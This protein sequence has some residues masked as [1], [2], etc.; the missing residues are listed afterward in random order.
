[1]KSGLTKSEGGQTQEAAT[2]SGVE[3]SMQ[4]G[5]A[6]Y[7]GVISDMGWGTTLLDRQADMGQASSRVLVEIY[8]GRTIYSMSGVDHGTALAMADGQR[9]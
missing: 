8:E 4:S 9:T 1:M 5:R 3:H 2:K 6:T 7:A